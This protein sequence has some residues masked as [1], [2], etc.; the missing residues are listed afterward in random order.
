MHV[1]AIACGAE[2][3]GCIFLQVAR[4]GTPWLAVGAAEL[5]WHAQGIQGCMYTCMSRFPVQP[6]LTSVGM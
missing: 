4:R 2:G 6:L 3:G 1:L 5:S